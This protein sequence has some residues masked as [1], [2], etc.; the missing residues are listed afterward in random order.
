MRQC[1]KANDG[2]ANGHS[3]D[4]RLRHEDA[5]DHYGCD[6]ERVCEYVHGHGR[7]GRPCHD[8]GYRA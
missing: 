1:Q 7:V 5:H 2:Y 3:G 4:V 8:H 6:H